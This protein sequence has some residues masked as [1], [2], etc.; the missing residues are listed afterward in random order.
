[1]PYLAHNRGII[2][3]NFCILMSDVVTIGAEVLEQKSAC[4][5]E[6]TSTETQELIAQMFDTMKQENGIGLAAPQIGV[7][8]QLAVIRAEGHELVLINP[9]I[10]Q[11]SDEMIVFREGCLSVPDKEL[12]ILRH[13]KVTIQYTDE[14]GKKTKLKVRD[15]LA[16]VCQH[17]IDHL[18]GILMTERYNRQKNLRQTFNIPQ[19]VL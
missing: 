3:N 12:D 10:T 15:F 18:N 14:H 2:I 16:V 13:Q 6:P 7:S 4:I 5:F 11:R 9:V 17:E 1:M 8:K 19:H